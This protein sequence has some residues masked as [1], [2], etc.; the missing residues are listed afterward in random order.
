MTYQVTLENESEPCYTGDIDKCRSYLRGRFVGI[1]KKS[2]KDSWD[3]DHIHVWD[4][5]TDITAMIERIKW[6]T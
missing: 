2:S 4:S 5:K 3:D 1:V 6:G